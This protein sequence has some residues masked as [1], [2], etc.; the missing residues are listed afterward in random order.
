MI[1]A[2]ALTRSASGLRLVIA[3]SS[4]WIL[5]AAPG[6]GSYPMILCRVCV[7]SC[8]SHGHFIRDA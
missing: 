5:S 2:A 4:F 8:G 1:A 6:V 3:S 7:A